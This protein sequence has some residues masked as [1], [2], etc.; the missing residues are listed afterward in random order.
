MARCGSG[1]PAVCGLA[2]SRAMAAVGAPGRDAAGLGAEAGRPDGEAGPDRRVLPGVPGDG[3]DRHVPAGGLRRLRREAVYLHGRQHRGR[4]RDLRQRHVRL[5]APWHGPGGRKALQRLGSGAHPPVWRTGRG[6]ARGYAC[7]PAAVL[8]GHD[9]PVRPGRGY[10][11]RSGAQP[12]RGVRC[13]P[14]RGERGLD[15]PARRGP[16]GQHPVHHRQHGDRAG[17]RY[18]AEGPV[19]V[20]RVLGT[21]GGAGRHAVAVRCDAGDARMVGRGRF[22]AA[23]SP[24]EVLR[25][26]GRGKGHG[27]GRRGHEQNAGA[28]RARISERAAAVGR[29]PARGYAAHRL[30][31]RGGQ[32]LCAGGDPQIARGRGSE[33]VPARLQARPYAG[34]DRAAGHRE[35]HPRAQDRGA[36]VLR[37]P[38]DGEREGG[39]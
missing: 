36:V 39:V 13:G 18:A 31:G 22:R 15:E 3:G 9:G 28:S 4:P 24:G 7:G 6:C 14:R 38:H 12:D 35:E 17:A 5:F 19:R 2:G 33:G 21:A 23:V 26:R 8:Q 37:F 30:P 20:R 1:A 10:K 27:R 29:N 25:D 32:R 34:A 16:Q 11:A